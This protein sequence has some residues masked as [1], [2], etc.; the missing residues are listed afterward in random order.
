MREDYW[1]VT[2]EEVVDK[3]GQNLAYWTEVLTA[4]GAEERKSNDVVDHLQKEFNV[5]RYWARTLT[6]RYAK[7]LR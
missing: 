7:G 5:P 6:T 3:T 4:F 1:V 2:D